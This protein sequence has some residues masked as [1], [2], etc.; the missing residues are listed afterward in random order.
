MSVPLT[1]NKGFERLNKIK[2]LKNY[3][4]T[5]I[6]FKLIIPCILLLFSSVLLLYILLSFQ[7]L[8]PLSGF[9]NLSLYFLSLFILYYTNIEKVVFQKESLLITKTNI[10]LK[11]RSIRVFYKDVKFIVIVEKGVKQGAN[12]NCRYLIRLSLIDNINIEFGETL[13]KSKIKEKYQISVFLIKNIYT[14]TVPDSLIKDEVKY[15]DYY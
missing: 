14:H 5:N 10:F 6:P 4:F 13:V 1:Y 12:D 9:I 2:L 11:K 15:L 7:I 8:N 3:A